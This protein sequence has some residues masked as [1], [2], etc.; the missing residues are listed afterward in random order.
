M[1]FFGL[2]KGEA[3]YKKQV[4]E[5]R[6]SKLKEGECNIDEKRRKAICNTKGKIKEY[7]LR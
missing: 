6:N 2:F 4:N 3:F 7:N 1:S 5:Y